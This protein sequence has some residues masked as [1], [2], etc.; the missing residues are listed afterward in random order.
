SKCS[1]QILIPNTTSVADTDVFV[2]AQDNI[3]PDLISIASSEDANYNFDVDINESDPLVMSLAAENTRIT[4]PPIPLPDAGT[5][6]TLTN[7]I[8]TFLRNWNTNKK[9]KFTP[10]LNSNSPAKRQRRSSPDNYR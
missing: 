7:K 8:P 2:D 6:P 4:S 1:Q 3:E 10:K 5:F 9:R